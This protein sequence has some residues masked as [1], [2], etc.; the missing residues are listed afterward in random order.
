MKSTKPVILVS[1]DDGFS[2]QGLHFLTEIMCE[3]GEVYVVAPEQHQSGMAHALTFQV[4]LRAKCRK[5]D[6]NLHRFLD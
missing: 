2:A 5:N 4:P 1:N 3:F 6:E